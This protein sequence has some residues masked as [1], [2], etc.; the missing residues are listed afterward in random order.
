M[1]AQKDIIEQ[2]QGLNFGPAWTEVDYQEVIPAQK[3]KAVATSKKFT[4]KWKSAPVAKYNLTLEGNLDICLHP[5]E[6]VLKVLVNTLKRSCKTY[7]LFSLIRLFFEKEDR[8]YMVVNAKQ[9]SSF[10]GFYCIE[11]ENIPFLSKEG[12]LDYIC[13]KNWDQY[14]DEECIEL[15]KPKGNFQSVNRCGITGVLLGPPN[16]H[17]YTDLI[18][19]HYEENLKG[20]CA[21]ES[22]I[23][24]ITNDHDQDLV[25]EWLNN[26][27]H[28]YRYKLKSDATRSFMSK[29]S[30]K[31]YL[32]NHA[33][34]SLIKKKAR[35]KLGVSDLGRIVDHDLRQ[36]L[37][38]YLASEMKWPINTANYFR[39]RF[40][41]LGFFIYKKGKKGISYICHIK[42]KVRDKNTQFSESVNA[43]I[44]VIE[45]D[46]G[47]LTV[48]DLPKVFFNLPNDE[49]P[50]E[51]L[52]NEQDVKKFKTD[53]TWLIKEGYITEFED[54]SLYI[55]PRT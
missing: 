15:E 32:L 23:A 11:S 9:G 50:W 12:A 46:N 40:H 43:L 53:L 6:R 3:H 20:R 1:N 47:N 41:H 51:S 26:M 8:F 44:E 27:T 17:L 21:Y 13:D 14:F 39:G 55:S 49:V 34:M 19:E 4:P 18:R 37:E 31:A 45:K 42:R 30:A 36:V 29:K 24:S 16:Y 28:G 48:S 22:F 35:I 52:V 54:N 33:E 7:Q 10:D 2:I 25:N 38:K 5:E